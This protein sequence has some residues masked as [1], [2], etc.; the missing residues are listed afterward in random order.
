M[1]TKRKDIKHEMKELKKKIAI[2]SLIHFELNFDPDFGTRGNILSEKNNVNGILRV[3][4][5]ESQRKSG[6]KKWHVGRG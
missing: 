3:E 5:G 2:N 4:D 1:E 6:P